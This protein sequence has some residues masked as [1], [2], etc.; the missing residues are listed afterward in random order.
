MCLQLSSQPREYSYFSPR[1]MATWAGPG[2][3][4]FKP[5]HKCE[6]SKACWVAS[7]SGFNVGSNAAVN[8]RGLCSGVC[9]ES[10][11]GSPLWN[12]VSDHQFIVSCVHSGPPA[13][14][15]DAKTETQED[16]WDRLQR[17]R[18][19]WHVLPHH[20][21]KNA[22][23]QSKP[24]GRAPPGVVILWSESGGTH[25][26]A[27]RTGLLVDVVVVVVFLTKTPVASSLA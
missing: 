11:D 15:G 10:C 2:Y 13:G 18:Q 27:G 7:S 12:N 8:T 24:Q 20:A 26:G 21:S 14:Q 16:L 3:W 9:S 19:L 1:T 5:K 23:S 22:F 25:W 17:W 4:Q 6:W